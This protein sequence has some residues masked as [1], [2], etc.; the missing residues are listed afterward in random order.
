ME[1]IS[2]VK[3]YAHLREE[4]INDGDTQLTSTELTSFA[5]RLKQIDST[6]F[7]SVKIIEDSKHDP[8]HVRREAYFDDE[9][10]AVI[11]IDVEETPIKQEDDQPNLYNTIEMTDFSNEY[12]DEAISEIKEYN[13]KKGYISN[14]NTSIDV[15]NSIRSEIRDGSFHEVNE[16]QEELERAQE[17]NQQVQEVYEE[18]I[19]EEL[20]PEQQERI[21][22]TQELKK[23]ISNELASMDELANPTYEEETIIEEPQI[24]EVVV[25]KEKPFLRLLQTDEELNSLDEIN[26]PRFKNEIKVRDLSETRDTRLEINS[27]KNEEIEETGSG[28]QILNIIIIVLIIAVL[29][30]AGILLYLLFM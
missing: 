3:K 1:K 13:L 26:E 14:A 29:I 7:D 28:N 12:L 23:S 30:V 25:K 15:F 24:E 19:V 2:R 16:I 5:E 4:L 9:G 17:S 27:F 11:S 18:F 21:A 6:Q 22:A 20:T 8:I 10:D